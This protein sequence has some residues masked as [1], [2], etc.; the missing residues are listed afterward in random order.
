MARTAS[1]AS[2]KKALT[3][4]RVNSESVNTIDA[5]RTDL[6]ISRCI[7]LALAPGWQCAHEKTDKS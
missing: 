6:M 1:G 2:E 3:S 4:C 7:I 5:R